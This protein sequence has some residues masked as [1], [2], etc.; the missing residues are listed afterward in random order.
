MRTLRKE[1]ATEEGVQLY[2]VFTNEQLAQIVQGRVR[3]KEQLSKIPGVGE[4]R[5]EKYGPRILHLLS[6]TWKA[7]HEASDGPVSEDHGT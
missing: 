6:T 1:I 5:V 3:T 7:T 4:T 2:A